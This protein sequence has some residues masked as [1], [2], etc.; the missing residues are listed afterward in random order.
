MNDQ[1]TLSGIDYAVFALY[2]VVTIG[3]GFAAGRMARRKPS[4]YFLGEKKLPW[5]VVGTSMV[6]SDISSET[7]IANVGIAYQ[8]GMVVATTGWNAWIIYSIFLFIFLPYYV[9]TGLYTMPQFLELRYNATCRYLFAVS[10]VIGYIF[11]LL[12]GS[13]YAG[14]LAIEQIFALQLSAELAT[15]IKWGIVFFAVTTGA[16]T[17]YGGMKASAWTDFMQMLVL[18]VAGLLLP[19]LAL[20]KTGGLFELAREMPD[21]F[22]MF[23]PPTHEQF[24]WTGVFTGFITVGLWYTCASQH[25]VQRV[26]SAKDE[27]HARMGVVS[28]GY[29]RI[30]TPLFFVI[31]GIAAI[32]LFP[33]LEK[34]DHAYLMLVKTLIPTGLKGLILA[35]MAAALMS[36]VSTVLNSTSTLLT[37]DIYKKV[38]KPNASNREQVLVGMIT[39]VVVLIASIFIAFSYI[40]NPEALFRQVQRIFFYIAPPFAVVFLLGLLWRRATA[41]AAVVTIIS[42]S[43]FLYLLQR[44]VPAASIPPIWDAIPWLTP[45]KQAYQHSALITWIFCMIVMIVTSLLTPPP[46]RDQVDRVIWNRSYLNLPPDERAHYRGWRNFILWW[47]I[48]VAIVIGIYGYFLWFGLTRH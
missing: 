36:T 28:A 12:A 31:P 16:Y 2:M 40:D 43:L 38:L 30:I 24:P 48:F 35:G 41:T 13:L 27:W 8:Y 21:K 39:G 46:P 45:Y 33:T 25:I 26:L 44:G 3:L 29:L 42:G 15:N 19:I 17:I 32:K 47:A 14:G 23:L 10:L 9:R 20:Q 6:A 7:F 37:I 1:A 4:D 22:D 11:T 18:L 34:P 5:Y